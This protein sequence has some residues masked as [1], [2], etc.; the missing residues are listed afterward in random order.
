MAEKGESNKTT[1][2]MR[3][4]TDSKINA[5]G[6]CLDRNTK[7]FFYLLGVPKTCATVTL[8]VAHDEEGIRNLGIGKI[9]RRNRN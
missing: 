2:I 4:A 7:L 8:H 1:K 5:K 6:R 3:N 9:K